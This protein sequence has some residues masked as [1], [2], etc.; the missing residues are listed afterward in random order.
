MRLIRGLAWLC[1][2][3]AG[4]APC[5]MAQPEAS[6]WGLRPLMRELAQVHS[7]SATFT[8]R[9]TLQ[10]LN[11]PLV[12]SGTLTYLA[13]A[14][15]RKRTLAPIPEDFVLDHGQVTLTGGP[16]NQTH[17]FSLADDPRI[18]G[19]VEGIRATLAGDLPAL[20]RF[21]TMR[22]TGNAA[23]WQLLL[24]PK[25]AGLAHF[26]K[27]ILILGSQNRI[28]AIDTAS[29]NGDHSEMGIAEDVSDAK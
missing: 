20:G 3:C 15:V 21:Y 26:I 18:G 25:D 4:S 11:A 19:L 10:M 5:A 9:E 13:P 16:Q 12:T 29:S 14:Y 8:E 7:A 1:A 24:Q 28:H 23:N 17:V 27:W 6:G 22:L 2:I